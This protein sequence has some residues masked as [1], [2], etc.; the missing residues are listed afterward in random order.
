MAPW[1]FTM[2][3]LRGALERRREV[4]RRWR[5]RTALRFAAFGKIVSLKPGA[6]ERSGDAARRETCLSKLVAS[7]PDF[8]AS[9]DANAVTWKDGTVM[10]FDDGK[11]EKD[12]ETRLNEPDLEDTFYAP[13]PLGRTGIPPAVDIDP[14]RVRYAPF[15]DKMYGDYKKGEVARKLVPVVWLPKHGGGTLKITS[16][17]NVAEKLRGVSAELDKLPD[18]FVKY[19]T[20]AGGTYHCR[21]IG[22]TTRPSAH[23]YGIAI[24]I[25][26]QWSDYW[27][28]RQQAGGT[29]PY[30]NRIPWEIVEIFEKHGFI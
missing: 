4:Y 1:H 12:F 6:V 9:H 24:D 8:L 28:W 20:P 16:V 11:G 19:L 10:M 14:G 22:G 27:R 25:N 23:G 18:S 5:D 7:Y 15:F 30:R 13:Y 26:V 17:N 2:D 3:E 29:S 21:A